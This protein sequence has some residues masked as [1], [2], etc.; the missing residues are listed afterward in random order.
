MQVY[1][2][3]EPKELKE[4]TTV[5]ELLQ[6]LGLNPKVVAVER[7]RELVT[8]SEHDRCVLKD[9]DRVEIVTLAGGG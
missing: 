6:Q 8:R 5:A 1:V 9:G 4:G 7:N 3:G 2:N